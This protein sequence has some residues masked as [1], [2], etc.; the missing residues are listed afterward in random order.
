M[1]HP[2]MRSSLDPR[3]NP[4]GRNNLA[5]KCPAGM[6]RFRNS[7][8]FL[9]QIFNAIGQVLL[10]FSKF[11]CSTIYSLPVSLTQMLVGW[12]NFLSLI[13]TD[14]SIPILLKTH[15][16]KVFPQTFP[17]GLGLGS[18]STWEGWPKSVPWEGWLINKSVQWVTHGYFYH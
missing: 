4:W 15:P 17:R 11:L 3:P 13:N 16:G 10:W 6:P 12:S 1:R 8:N 5:T 14:G 2:C 18:R 9:F 7:A